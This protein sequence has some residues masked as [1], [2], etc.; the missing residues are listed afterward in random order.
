MSLSTDLPELSS[1]RDKA[2]YLNSK[3]A[4]YEQ[5]ISCWIALSPFFPVIGL[6][7]LLEYM[8]KKKRLEY[9]IITMLTTWQNDLTGYTFEFK[10][11]SYQF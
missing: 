2:L 6:F 4:E 11:L 7:L 9:L 8:D 5:G 3:I 1:P 10:G